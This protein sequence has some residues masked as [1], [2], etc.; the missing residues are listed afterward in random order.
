MRGLRGWSAW[1]VCLLVSATIA[2]EFPLSLS[3]A[4]SVAYASRRA[5]LRVI[6]MAGSVVLVLDGMGP[7]PDVRIERDGQNWE[8]Q[9]LTPEP[10]TLPGGVRQ[11]AL[12]EIGMASVVLEGSGRSFVLSIEPLPGRSIP[13]PVIAS[14]GLAVRMS[15]KAPPLPEMTAGSY[16]L[17]SPGAVR[18]PTFVPPL[19]KRAM[20]PPVGDMAVG[21]MF[22]RNPSFVPLKGPPVTLTTRNA[23]PRDVLMLLAKMGGYNFA[24][25][26]SGSSGSDGDDGGR[27]ITVS[28]NQEPLDKAFNFVL[29]SSGLQ[30]KLEDRTVLVGANVLMKTTGNQVSRVYRLNQVSPD[31]AAD[32]LANLGATITKTNTIT[33]TS[34]E[35]SSTG[36]STANASASTSQQSTQTVIESF[37]ASQGP[38]LGLIGTTDKR[39]GTITLIGNSYLVTIAENYLKQ[40]D[41]R[42]RQVAV[43][44]KILNVDLKNDTSIRNDFSTM[45]GDTFIVSNDG[46][47]MVNFG[48]LKPASSGGGTFVPG[49]TPLTGAY[50]FALPE[51]QMFLDVPYSQTPYSPPRRTREF[52]SNSYVDPV[53]GNVIQGER[54]RTPRAGFGPYANPQ[55]PGIT[56]ITQDAKGVTTV[57]YET[58]K[59]FKYPQNQLFDYLTAL[60][61]SNSAK[62]ISN[63]TLLV[64]EGESA[65]VQAVESV[66][67]DVSVTDNANSTT[68]TTTTREDAGLL[69]KVEAE[70]IDDNG[71]IT[72]RL[73]PE[74]SV[75]VPGETVPAGGIPIKLFNIVK[76]QLDSGKIRLRDGQ[77]LF[78]TG[79]ITDSE[80]IIVKKWPVLGDIPFFGQFFR[81]SATGRTKRELIIVVTPRIIDDEQGGAYGYGYQPSTQEA[82]KLIYQ[83]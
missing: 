45:I 10:V 7:K 13:N 3:R 65:Q 55:Q 78:L 54:V 31:G 43:N 48:N 27:P 20:A 77:T 79:V 51:D 12:P 57:E 21:S 16:D 9:I 5:D 37:G 46:Q 4:G 47:A 62:T 41:L 2:L 67:T 74:V 33:T 28:F 58:P 83:P 80:N 49:Q 68:T 39:L 53:T 24:Y 71:F 34:N 30:A 52:L 1:S 81:S 35:S 42:K 19:R 40:L 15:F 73:Q 69:L 17:T 56:K 82:R 72:L 70:K 59:N 60:V 63:P 61:T 50:P 6:R 14:D 75:P 29:L 76:R 36:V 8:A 32:Y 11:F 23:P 64:Q 66:I 26:G 38:L 25:S 18:K 22:L 44:V